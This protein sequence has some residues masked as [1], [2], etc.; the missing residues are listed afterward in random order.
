MASLIST[1]PQWKREWSKTDKGSYAIN[2]IILAFH[3][4]KDGI[5]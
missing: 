2:L 3:I 1:C 4:F 5:M